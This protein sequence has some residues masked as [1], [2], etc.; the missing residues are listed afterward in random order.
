MREHNLATKKGMASLYLVAFT[1]LL[2]GIV[3]LSFTQ[4]MITESKESSNSELSQSAYDSAMAGVEDARLALLKYK[5]CIARGFTSKSTPSGDS[6]ELDTT[7]C[8][9]AIK[10]V[11]ENE[12]LYDSNGQLINSGNCDITSNVLG[13]DDSDGEVI[14]QETVGSEDYANTNQAY[15]C[16][17]ISEESPDYRSTLTTSDRVRVIP[18]HTKY[19]EGVVGAKIQ[20]YS[21]SDR[22]G[23]GWDTSVTD[24]NKFYK[25][26]EA[27]ENLPIITAE[28]FQTDKSF[29]MA[30]LD[31]NNETNSGTDH[32]LITLYPENSVAKNESPDSTDGVGTFVTAKDLLEV[33]NKNSFLATGAAYEDGYRGADAL[34]KM[35]SCGYNNSFRCRSTIQFPATYDGNTVAY[36]NVNGPFRSEATFFLRV[37]LPYGTPDLDFSVTLCKGFDA[38]GNCDVA[39]FNGVQAVVD[40]TG[41][42]STLYRRV[43]ARIDL[44][45]SNFPYPEFAI[46]I[47]G[48][49]SIEKNFWVA[50]NCWKTADDGQ[51][52]TC[53]NNGTVY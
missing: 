26:A 31:I 20:W 15:T 13:R 36:D 49:G 6:P 27:A 33:S 3:T 38:D 51:V 53:A 48:D 39:N 7:G 19:Y 44:V 37:T 34:P 28:L 47:T 4:I 43:E 41:R 46:Q 23:K 16:V 12:A 21:A 32:A 5:D 25:K 2:L 1:T 50:K 24:S 22:D 14:I 10:M 11:E 9:N 45:D 18:L 42:A 17:M 30:E 8:V 35:V 52:L 40:S 29:T